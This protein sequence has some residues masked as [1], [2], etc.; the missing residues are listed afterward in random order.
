LRT[1]AAWLL[2][3]VGVAACGGSEKPADDPAGSEADPSELR[4]SQ[5]DD[6]SDES[7][8]QDIEVEGTRGKLERADIE[9]GME[10]HSAAL[11][12]CYTA[13]SRR[14]RYVSGKLEL[15]YVVAKD[16]GVKQV[17][18]AQSDLGAWGVERCLLDIA[19]TMTFVRP[20]GG[21]AEFSVPLDFSGSRPITWWDEERAE[22][23]VGDVIGELGECPGN[24]SDVWV[25]AYVGARGKVTSVGFASAA[26]TPI[27]QDWGDCAESKVKSWVLTDPRGRPAKLSFRFNP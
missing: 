6:D 5:S 7:A 13:V 3:A 26:K 14:T 20:R 2:A 23:E 9:Q 4:A 16:G 1:C 11:A 17:Q 25:T 21:E 15:K 27:T 22:R 18:I 24:A 10:P 12:Q 19:G 8:P